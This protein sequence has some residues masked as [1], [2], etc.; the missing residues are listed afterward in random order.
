MSF[1]CPSKKED[2]T[3]VDLK[4]VISIYFCWRSDVTL[5]SAVALTLLSIVETKEHGV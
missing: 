3:M 4:S 2:L 1:D 5:V